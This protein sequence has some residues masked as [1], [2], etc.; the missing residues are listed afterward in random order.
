MLDYMRKNAGS[1]VIRFILFGIVITFAFWGVGGFGPETN[2]VMTIDKVK[3][4]YNEYNDIYNALYESY[5]NVY[6]QLDAAVIAELDIRGQALEALKE[7]Y[8]LLESARRLNITATE[9]EVLSEITGNGLFFEA[10]AFS[11][12]L[13]QAFLDLNRL[14]RES[15]ETSLAKDLVIRKV[16]D[17]IKLSAVV[18]P[19][20]VQDNL[21]LIS[22]RIA[23][24]GL[25]LDPNR[26]VRDV[27]APS[28]EDLLDYYEDNAEYYRLP[29]R[30]TQAVVILDREEMVDRVD[31]T[32]EEIEDWY[33]DRNF[34]Y[35]EPASFKLRHILFAL[36]ENAGVDSIT[37]IR[38]LAQQV[39]QDIQDGLTSFE[40]AAR[41]WSDD[42]ETAA[43][44]GVL[45]FMS[46][47]ELD[48][49]ILDVSIS[50]EDGDI[51][52]PV[53]T[54]RGF[55][56]F[57]V[58]DRRQ[59]RQ[60]P[61][62]EVRDSIEAQI[63]EEKTLDTALDLADDLIERV[64]SSETMTLQEA[65]QESELAVVI[66]PPFSRDQLPG[67]VELPAGLLRSAFDLEENELGDIYEEGSR[68]YL[69]Q[70]IRRTESYIPEFEDVREPLEGGLLI[71]RALDKAYVKGE[72]IAEQISE[73]SSLRD[74]ARELGIPV[75][76]TSPFTILDR[77]LPE[78]GGPENLVREAFTIA[79]PGGAVLVEGD[80]Y[81]Y[82]L[83]LRE[84]LPPDTEFVES[85]RAV[86][87][88]A[89][90]KQREQDILYSHIQKLKE[91]LGD[92]IVVNEQFL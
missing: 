28:E 1:W 83:V 13:Y 44:G 4:P 85:Q 55:E 7:R 21:N 20:E 36:P 66:T 59:E 53:P 33:D 81:H 2:I 82:L 52:E 10:G 38:S 31:V 39:A 86:V 11:P 61:L 58:M 73:G 41:Q 72:Q 12:R 68:I 57:S 67:T 17:L 30:F 80:Q 42:G 75:R 45:G 50:L 70:V 9:E 27:P 5:R 62:D 46:E 69:S 87:E 25:V 60:I 15:Y 43:S 48:Q 34:E 63:R 14:T 71:K 22:R 6:D 88:E 92:K 47:D 29:E 3:V 19:Q 74:I 24:D 65:A 32:S 76:T 8:L 49:A 56:L 16:T 77:S 78:L 90:R 18:T 40:E 51:S 35:L 91:E 64:E 23:V 26:F 37:E 79:E 89:I 54:Q 84:V